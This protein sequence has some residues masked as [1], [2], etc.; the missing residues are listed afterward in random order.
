MLIKEL[1]LG[2]DD[3]PVGENLAGGGGENAG[4]S[5][6]PNVAFACHI[7]CTF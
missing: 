4:T 3:V 5:H 7:L 6:V 1:L 2:S